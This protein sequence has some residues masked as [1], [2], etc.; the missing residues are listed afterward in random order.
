MKRVIQ[1]YLQDPLAEM[2]LAGE[3][4]DGDMVAISSQGNVL[5][6]NGKAPKTAEIAPFEAPIPKRKLN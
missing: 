5:T 4:K 2:I 1:R 3:V 6:F